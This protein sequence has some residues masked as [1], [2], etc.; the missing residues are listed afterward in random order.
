MST[1]R[2][3][4]TATE[5]STPLERMNLV[6]ELIGELLNQTAEPATELMLD[7]LLTEANAIRDAIRK[8]DAKDQAEHLSDWEARS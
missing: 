8:E 4:I 2:A 3:E 1:T 5:L 7:G 6:C